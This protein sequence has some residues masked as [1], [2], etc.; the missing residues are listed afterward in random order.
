MALETRIYQKERTIK[1]AAL[2]KASLSDMYHSRFLARQLAERDIKA[3]YRQSYLGIIW[4]FIL[5]LTTAF[6][7]IILNTS[8]TVKLSDTGIPYP[9]YAFS[10]TLI[11][12]IIVAAINSPM[13]STNAAKGILTK[14][15]FPK[16]A[17]LLS[18]IYKLLFDSSIKVILLVVFVF[19]YGV[20]IHWSLLLFPMVILGAI[21]FGTT[22]GLFVT[23]LGLLYKDIGKI[24]TFGMQFLMYVTPVVYAI[25][26]TGI[27]KTVMEWNPITPI[28]LTARDVVVG[29]QPEYL[30]YFLGVLL[31]CVPLLFLGLI[32][33][34]IAIPIIVERL[35]A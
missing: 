6:V 10:G 25:P 27:M 7:W 5:P 16:E 11:W 26:K 4:A 3:Q 2:L 28:I 22:L 32:V 1:F 30:A 20:G 8:G 23:P 24:I 13:Q 33:Y 34:R 17:L 19:F 9:V 29:E 31:V 12:S 14:I 35:S 21:L 18:G 15:N